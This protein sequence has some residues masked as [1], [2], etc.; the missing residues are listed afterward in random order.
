[1]EKLFSCSNMHCA[2]CKGNI[3][4]ALNKLNGVIK[5]EANP[6]TSSVK[7]EVNKNVT[8]EDIIN[9][10][11]E[12]GYDLIK[13]DDDSELLLKKDNSKFLFIRIIIGLIL[14]VP[15]MYLGMGVMYPD[16]IPDFLKD[17]I[18]VNEYI[19]LGLTLIII[20]L[21]FN[22]Y[23][24]G[25]KALIKLSPNMDSL[26][27]LGSIFSLIYS[28]YLIITHTINPTISYEHTHLYLDSAAMILVIVSIGKYIELLS[29]RKAKNTISEL[30]KLRPKMAH[31]VKSGSIIDIETKFLKLK[32]IIL[33]K[34]GEVIPSDG[35]VI[36]GVSS[37]DESLI[38]G[39]SL[40]IIKKEDDEVIGGSINGEGSLQI[41]ITKEKKDSI[42]SKIISLVM[43]ASNMD[44]KLTRKIDVVSRYFTPIILALSLLTFILW[45][46]ISPTHSFDEAFRYGVGVM[47]I[48]CPCAL[49]LATPISLLVGSSVFAK[50]GVL[51]NKSEAIEVL[52]D[53]DTLILDKTNTITKGELEVEKANILIKT[54]Q[55]LDEIY[56][57]EKYSSHPL[58]KGIVNYLSKNKIS[59][60]FIS[61]S[62]EP[63]KGVYGSFKDNTIYIGNLN[64]LKDYHKDIDNELLKEINDGIDEG[65]LPLIAFSNDEI[66]AIFYLKDHLKDNAK[67]FINEAYKYF[68]NI[69]LLTGD[70]KIIANK[71]AE[72]VGIKDV[73]SEVLPMDKDNVI[74]KLQKEGHKVVMVGDGVNDSI[75]LNRAEVGIG[76]AKGSDIA[77]SS[78]D[79]ILMRSDLMD[80]INI[81]KISKKIR[82][83]I[84]T[85]LFWAF[86]YNIIFIP[87]AAGCFSTFG[88]VLE[89]MYCS[90]LMALSSVTVCLNAL[91]LFLTT[92]RNNK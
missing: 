32:D 69:I 26:V 43:E 15:L 36:S 8:D 42:L 41:L 2:A 11:K 91:T 22:Y 63:G 71:I 28:I 56:T 12:A 65:L 45:I 4:R 40:P 17:P 86:I 58:A 76:I 38:S 34:P 51:V 52:K 59:D 55:I 62:I 54:S 48:S 14:L 10:C 73:I 75:A 27:F 50:N 92:K 88:V 13:I 5:C 9:T 46:S 67:D 6:I 84:T 47:V 37:V 60:N 89:P 16:A 81:I 85:N 24:D 30:L 64:Y 90:M 33:V 3:E 20:G 19:Q 61:T 57:L 18:Y 66:F 35:L 79:F 25:F 7:V 39:E 77:L 53:V 78:S 21:F 72:E 1:M 68:K 70:N 80:I 23:K 87:I 29:K 31:L 83:N 82:F 74:Q 49:G 44:S